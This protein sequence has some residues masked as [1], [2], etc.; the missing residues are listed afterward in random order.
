VVLVLALAGCS[1]GA[2]PDAAPP[3]DLIEREVFVETFVDL[4]IAALD[5]PAW[6]ITPAERDSVLAAHGV[7]AEQIEQFVLHHG[8]DVR[9]MRELWDEVDARILER[10]APDTDSAGGG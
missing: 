4:R 8:R 10:L 2:E 3:P 7:T 6:V 1:G 5:N 9:W